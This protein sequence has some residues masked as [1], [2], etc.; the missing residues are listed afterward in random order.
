MLQPFLSLNLLPMRIIQRR[1]VHWDNAL[2][3]LTRTGQTIT[4]GLHCTSSKTY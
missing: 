4:V 3:Q 1:A 2:L